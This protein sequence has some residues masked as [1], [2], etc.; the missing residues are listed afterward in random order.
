MYINPNTLIPKIMLFYNIRLQTQVYIIVGNA[1]I[2]IV[3]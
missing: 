1:N 2:I 3:Q